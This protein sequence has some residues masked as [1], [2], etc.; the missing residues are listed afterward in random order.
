MC[1]TSKRSFIGNSISPPGHPCPRHCLPEA[2]HGSSPNVTLPMLRPP[3]TLAPS[4]K[5][6]SVH[7]VGPVG[8]ETKTPIPVVCLK[9]LG[10]WPH[11]T[12]RDTA[13]TCLPV[14]SRLMPVVHCSDADKSFRK[15]LGCFF[16]EGRPPCLLSSQI[17]VSAFRTSISF[18]HL[19]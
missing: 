13:M 11:P 15:N 8:S 16:G 17:Y 18:Q 2:S 19:F 1:N 9:H 3:V 10:P 5:G 12:R 4:A 14:T 7:G 6:A